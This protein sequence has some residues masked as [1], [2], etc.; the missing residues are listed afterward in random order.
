MVSYLIILIMSVFIETLT[1]D[2]ILRRW[3]ENPELPKKDYT[4]ISW[5]RVG[6]PE[7]NLPPTVDEV[8]KY[9]ERLKELNPSNGLLKEK[10]VFS[11]FKKKTI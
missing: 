7:N 6:K 3:K 4:W 1:I 10:E 2:Y 8:Q 5:W 11:G 9:F